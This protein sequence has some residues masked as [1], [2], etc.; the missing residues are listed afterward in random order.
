VLDSVPIVVNGFVLLEFMIGF[1]FGFRFD[2]ELDSI[3]L[4]VF[5]S[6][7]VFAK[8]LKFTL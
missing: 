4:D 2:V 7:T 3:S 6:D 8:L 1:P 5:D